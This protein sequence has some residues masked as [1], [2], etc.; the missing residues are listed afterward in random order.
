MAWYRVGSITVTNGSV[1]VSGAGTAWISNAAIGEALYAPDGRLYE[2]VNIASDTTITL[3]SAYL[4]ATASAQAYVIVPSQSYIRDLAAQAADLVN[5][6]STIYN[7]V[8]QGKF[9][10]GTLGAPGIRFSDD[11]DTGFYRS[12]SN[13]VTF[14]AGGT[15]IFKYNLTG[16][17]QLTSVNLDGGTIDGTTIGATTPSTGAFTTLS[18]TSTTTL[19][20]TTIPASKTL[21]DTDSSQTLTGKTLT[22]PVLGGT[23][24]GTY[25]L[26]GTPTFPASVVLTTGAQTLASKTLTN[27]VINGFTGDTGII[28]IGSGQ[29]YKDAS[30]NVG[31]GTASPNVRLEVSATAAVVARFNSTNGLGSNIALQKSGTTYGIIG[32]TSTITG[33]GTDYTPIIFAEGGLGINFAT[34]GDATIKAKLD[35]SG[36]LLVG[37]TSASGKITSYSTSEWNLTCVRT[38]TVTNGHIQFINGNGQVG[39]I[40]TNGSTTTY[41]TSSDYRLKENVAPMQNALATVA[42][43]KPCTYT[44]KADGSAGQGF[45]A[46]E[47]QAVVPDAV[48]GEKDAVDADGK[49]QYQGVDTSFLVAT[50]VA[51][52]Q[53]LKAEF[54]AYKAA[55]P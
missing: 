17:L 21:V 16:G 32:A 47:L 43:L 7:T 9:G 41:A 14:V 42:Q 51:A 6:Y 23:V 13:E 27:P 48:T 55:H 53:E 40:T 46:H 19:N 5:N 24:T 45:I 2:I 54:D 3:Q 25:T 10:D 22:A 39:S 30:G 36:N 8:G 38:G 20:G 12:A 44:W 33:T 49:P 28:N 37:T 34:N 35:A 11:L 50:L 18:S 1:T 29:V 26:G 31:V 4:G 52:I 15:A